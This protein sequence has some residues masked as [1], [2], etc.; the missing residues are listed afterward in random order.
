MAVQQRI[1]KGHI[2]HF[3]V[4]SFG[5]LGVLCVL[6]SHSWS[7]FSLAMMYTLV[8][9]DKEGFISEEARHEVVC[10]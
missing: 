3:Q 9:Q 5:Y 4:L 6:M 7:L 1:W 2:S 8:R 10:A